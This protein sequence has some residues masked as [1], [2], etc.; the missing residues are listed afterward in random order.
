MAFNCRHQVASSQNG[1]SSVRHRV[2]SIRCLFCSL[3]YPHV[4]FKSPYIYLYLTS[5]S[6]P[7]KQRMKSIIVEL[8]RILTTGHCL[9]DYQGTC[10][11][12]V[13]CPKENKYFVTKNLPVV[14]IYPVVRIIMHT[15]LILGCSVIP[16]IAVSSHWYQSIHPSIHPSISTTQIS[17][18]PSIPSSSSETQRQSV[19][20]GEKTQR[21]FSSTDGR[22]PGY[23]VSTGHFQTVKRMLARDCVQ[24][25]NSIF[26]VLYVCSYST[27]FV[28]PYLSGSFTKETFIL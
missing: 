28:S 11:C 15:C 19:W 3:L 21:K 6:C 1:K 7:L 27:A 9:F 20:S 26:W 4:T 13:I 8:W 17:I 24:S 16:V 18:R 2:R 25:A 5:G 23:R 12:H 22:A 10:S 14:F